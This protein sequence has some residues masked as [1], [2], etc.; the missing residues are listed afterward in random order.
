MP[1]VRSAQLTQDRLHV[2]LGPQRD[3]LLWKQFECAL[4]A[5]CA[6]KVPKRVPVSSSMCGVVTVVA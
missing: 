5:C 2:G 6:V 3:R 1:Y 4:N